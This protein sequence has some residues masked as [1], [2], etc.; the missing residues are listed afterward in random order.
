MVYST[1]ADFLPNWDISR[2]FPLLLKLRCAGNIIFI[3][4]CF[5]AHLLEM[6]ILKREGVWIDLSLFTVYLT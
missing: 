6:E 2:G 5:V 1:L 4:G 3:F